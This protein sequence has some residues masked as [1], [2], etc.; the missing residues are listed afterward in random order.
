MYREHWRQRSATKGA[1]IF[2][3]LNAISPTAPKKGPNEAGFYL[4]KGKVSY[5]LRITALHSSDLIMSF[6]LGTQPKWTFS[7]LQMGSFFSFS[8]FFLPHISRFPPSHS[9]LIGLKA[10]TAAITLEQFHLDSH[11]SLQAVSLCHSRS[12]NVPKR[13]SGTSR[14]TIQKDN[15]HKHVKT[16]TCRGWRSDKEY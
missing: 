11:S 3:A 16:L 8:F 5:Q 7:L 13:T 4:L 12:A 6:R 1:W 15:S 14:V 9:I 10:I 2:L